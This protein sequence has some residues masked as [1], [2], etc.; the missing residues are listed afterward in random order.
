[1]NHGSVGVLLTAQS[2]FG[3]LHRRLH[4]L[5]YKW[6]RG[7]AHLFR[8]R[9]LKFYEFREAEQGPGI[10]VNDRADFTYQAGIW[11]KATS[12]YYQVRITCWR[13]PPA[14]RLAYHEDGA[15]GRECRRLLQ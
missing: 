10:C 8:G 6:L 12:S 3:D 2:T 13:T 11:T 4:P 7:L 15:I 9:R 1:M 5:D 14:P